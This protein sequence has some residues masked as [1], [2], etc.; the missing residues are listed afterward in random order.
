MS[1][2]I[3]GWRNGRPFSIFARAYLS[4]F[5]SSTSAAGNAAQGWIGLRY[6]PLAIVNL[7]LEASKLVGLDDE[8]L[9][10][11]S[12]RGAISGG[13]GLEPEMTARDWTYAHYYAD[14]SY[15]FEHD[16]TYALAEGRLGQAFLLDEA[17]TTLTPYALVRADFDSGRIDEEALGAGV[18]LSLRHWFD[19]TDT[20]AHRGFVDLDFQ[21]RERIA[22]SERASGVL[23]TVTIGR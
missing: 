4:E 23:V 15:L 9:D 20:V 13:A 10:D 1:R 21:V 17:S 8:G 12:V 22:G 18:G 11:W 14:V 6:K 5:Q 7:N 16:T 2:R 19:A 3:G